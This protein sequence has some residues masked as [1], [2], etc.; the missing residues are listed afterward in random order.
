VV[1]T[2]TRA[3]FYSDDIKIKL[4]FKIMAIEKLISTQNKIMHDYYNVHFENII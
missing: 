3:A 2:P 4:T 1:T